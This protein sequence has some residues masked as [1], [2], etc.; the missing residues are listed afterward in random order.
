MYYFFGFCEVL[1][2]LLEEGLDVVWYCYEVL[3]CVI[4][5]VVDVWGEG[6]LMVLNVVD[7]VD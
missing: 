6:G 7:F 3:V 1:D 2:M 5:V 4:W